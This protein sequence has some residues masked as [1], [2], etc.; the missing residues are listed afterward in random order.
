[1]D[2]KV[3]RETDTSVSFGVG[4][5]TNMPSNR[6]P[7][8]DSFFS[9]GG[10]KSCFEGIGWIDIHYPCRT[11][12]RVFIRMN[13]PNEYHT[14]ERLEELVKSLFDILLIPSEETFAVYYSTIDEECCILPEDF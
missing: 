5:L 8:S 13:I 12:P 1:L 10:P 3:E 7:D 11:Q 2:A 14:F 9:F 4:R 6:P